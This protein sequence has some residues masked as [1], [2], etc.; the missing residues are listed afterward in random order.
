[1]LEEGATYRCPESNCGCEV[2]V[3]KGAPAAEAGDDD[4][5]TCCCGTKREKQ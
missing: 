3:T 4:A 2:K 1:M 5:P